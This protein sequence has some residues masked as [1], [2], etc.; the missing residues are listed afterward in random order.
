MYK[1]FGAKH[2]YSTSA[3]GENHLAVTIGP[4][5]KE[6]SVDDGTET[7]FTYWR[8]KDGEACT[9]EEHSR[10]CLEIWQ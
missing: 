5:K 3:P 10:Y 6:F 1:R 4:S 7:G 9:N 8:K 2:F